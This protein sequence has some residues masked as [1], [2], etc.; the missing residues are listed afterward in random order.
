MEKSASDPAVAKTLRQGLLSNRCATSRP[1]RITARCRLRPCPGG[2]FLAH[3]RYSN[4]C[5]RA[6]HDTVGSVA[7]DVY[8]SPTPVAVAA[9]WLCLGRCRSHP[10][11]P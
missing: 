10:S 8:R 4:G 9:R 11:L 3:R 6:R 2:W 5:G 1:P 7:R